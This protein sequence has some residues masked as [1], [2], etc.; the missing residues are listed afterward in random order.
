MPHSFNGTFTVN[1]HL[2]EDGDAKLCQELY[3]TF[4]TS[5]NKYSNRMMN[6]ATPEIWT[7]LFATYDSPEYINVHGQFVPST[8]KQ[9]HIDPSPPN[10]KKQ[11]VDSLNIR[12]LQFERPQQ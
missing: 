2:H 8:R 7:A 6:L 10:P 11:M 5:C 3:W 12:W 9:V 4:L 1:N